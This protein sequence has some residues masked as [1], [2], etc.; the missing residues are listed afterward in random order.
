MI[1]I[2]RHAL[3][4]RLH[5]KGIGRVHHFHA[6]A[7]AIAVGLYLIL[8]DLKDFKEWLRLG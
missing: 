8:T 3:G 7:I 4:P 2:E 6:G 5:I 1:H